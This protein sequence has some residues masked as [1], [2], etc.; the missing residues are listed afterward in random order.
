MAQLIG[1]DFPGNV[2]ELR[3]LLERASLMADGDT[4]LSKHLALDADFGQLPNLAATVSRHPSLTDSQLAERVNGYCGSREEL[5]TS[6]G[7]SVRT[8]YRRLNAI[9]DQGAVK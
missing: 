8:L 6:L 9:R 1:Y 2:R 7:M 5:A 4:L 3:N